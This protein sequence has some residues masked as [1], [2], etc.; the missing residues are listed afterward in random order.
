MVVA[1][2]LGLIYN[3]VI[4][5]GYGPDEGRHINYV[6][7]LLN[8]GVLPYQVPDPN[9]PGQIKEYGDAHTF[10]PPLYHAL[11]VPFYAVL[12]FLPGESE[13]HVLRVL[14][15]FLCVGALP[16]FYEVALRAG[17]GDRWLARLVTA[18]VALLPF[19]V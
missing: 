6:K 7:L 12:R 4:L 18:Q 19:S 14:S 11:F 2:L 17:G 1:T 13:W 16:F 15:L 3:G 5:L 8:E 10:H 9:R